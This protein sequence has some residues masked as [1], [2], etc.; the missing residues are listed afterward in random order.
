MADTATDLMLK[1]SQVPPPPLA[2][3]RNDL[4]DTVESILLNALAKNPDKRYQSA[5]AFAEDLSDAIRAD[6]DEETIVI[7]KVGPEA[8]APGNNL[9]KTAFIVLAGMSVMAFGLIYW[10]NT[11]N[12]DP[13]TMLP[14]DE[15][16]QPVQPLNPATGANEVGNLMTLPPGTLL[17]GEDP[18]NP[19]SFGGDGYDP[20]ANVPAPRPGGSAG[21]NPLEYPAYPVGPGDES[22]TLPNDGRSIFMPNPDG[23]GVILVPKYVEPKDTPKPEASRTPAVGKSPADPAVKPSPAA[24]EKPAVKPAPS[25]KPETPAAKPAETKPKPTAPP[26]SKNTGKLKSGQEQDT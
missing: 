10:T 8:V 13:Q 1:H 23:S 17:E 4:P 16:S 24:G 14:T 26:S 7:P 3:F 12:R 2:A 6:R 5:A 22:I 15:N 9:W 18:L 11:A 21:T 19:G 25:K 20:W